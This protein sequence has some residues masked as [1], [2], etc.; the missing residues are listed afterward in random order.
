MSGCILGKLSLEIADP[1]DMIQSLLQLSFSDWQ[2]DI[3][4]VLQE[5]IERADLLKSTNPEALAAF[6]LNSYQGALLRSKADRSSKPLDTFMSFAF[7]HLL[8]R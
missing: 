5:A 8:K 3:A 4:H 2:A 1:S 7:H 6:L